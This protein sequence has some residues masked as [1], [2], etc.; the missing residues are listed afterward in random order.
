M[1][2][3]RPAA[4]EV[5]PHA[6]GDAEHSNTPKRKEGTNAGAR[7]DRGSCN[8]EDM[9][10]S[11]TQ[12]PTPRKIGLFKVASPTPRERFPDS[13]ENA[14]ESHEIY[15][16]EK[17]TH[18]RENEKIAEARSVQ[19]GAHISPTPLSVDGSVSH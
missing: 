5:K 18:E 17:G 8:G 19:C 9:H 2:E 10:A 11:A 16:R 3:N 12:R 14:I 13:K 4:N 6:E 7:T 15:K 1:N